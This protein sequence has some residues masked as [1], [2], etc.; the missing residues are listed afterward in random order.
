MG[1]IDMPARD[2]SAKAQLKL[3]LPEPLRARL[4]VEA[5]GNGYSL[6]YEVMRRLEQSIQNDDMGNLVFGDQDI[7]RSVYLIA[8]II[9]ALEKKTGHRLANDPK[10][11]VDALEASK[12]FALFSTELSGIGQDL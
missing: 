7:F 3:R 8:G 4:E 2:R 9:R 11:F 12:N 1:H 6:N 10:I 5:K